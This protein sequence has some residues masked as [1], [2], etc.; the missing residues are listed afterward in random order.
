MQ[1]LCKRLLLSMERHCN[2]LA[3]K[4]Q[5]RQLTYTD[6]YAEVK[7]HITYLKK[8]EIEQGDCILI[9]GEKSCEML[10]I[11]LACIFCNITYVPIEKPISNHR[12]QKIINDS[13]ANAYFITGKGIKKLND[14]KLKST[15]TLIF[16]TSGSTGVPKAVLI[17]ENNILNFVDWA[18]YKF[19][20]VAS[21]RFCAFAPWHFDLCILDVFAALLSGGSIFCVPS[22]LKAFPYSLVE[23]LNQ[24]K[25]TVIYAVPTALRHLVKHGHWTPVN[26]QT[27]RCILFAGESYPINEL[28]KLRRIFQKPIIAN[29]YGPTETNVCSFCD[30]PSVKL[31]DK[32]S[33]LPIGKGI[34]GF[35]LYVVNLEN[36]ILKKNDNIGE[37]ICTG[38][39]ISEAYINDRDNKA[40]VYFQNQPAYRTGDL[41][42]ITRNGLVFMGRKDRQ[43]KHHGYRIDPLEIEEHLRQHRS[44]YDAAVL[45]FKNQLIACIAGN[46]QKCNLSTLASHCL[47]HF[48]DYC[49]PKRFF[50][51]EN[52]I[53]IK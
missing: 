14:I 11:I 20:F 39:T 53:F 38:E 8:C 25:I 7:S 47:R 43:L 42:K 41:V 19:K 16:Y 2:L 33:E 34:P 10:A 21:D 28:K 30:I 44:V 13:C 37:L 4:D 9:I 18:L 32:W 48:P 24:M 12:I 1:S 49:C 51:F 17:K 3:I 5:Y 27:I 23:W 26:H 35:S 50:L 40:F 31:L 29:L 52:F 22:S 36:Q 45:V 15:A 46:H 6:L